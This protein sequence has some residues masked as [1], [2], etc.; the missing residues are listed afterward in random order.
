M[1]L[2][3]LIVDDS[4]HFKEAARLLLEADGIAVV[5][6]VS[7]TAETLRSI[8][9]LRP[10]LVLVDIDLGEENGFDLA[11]RLYEEAGDRPPRVI[12][13]STYDE[14]D[15]AEMIA[16]SPA[17]AFLSKPRLSGRAIDEILRGADA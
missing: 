12:L 11:L 13:I 6:T 4:D 2:R 7:T 15:F 16:T 1:P 9:E 5:G 8:Q 17:L 3:C 14:Q 10:D